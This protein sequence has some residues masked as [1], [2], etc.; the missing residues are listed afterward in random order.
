MDKRGVR[1]SVSSDNFLGYDLNSNGCLNTRTRFGCQSNWPDMLR[2]ARKL[3]VKVIFSN[4][5]AEIVYD[6]LTLNTT[7]KL[8]S[9][10]F[11]SP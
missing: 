1:M 9:R 3:G 4:G 8:Q 5:K 10:L 6:D 7:P 2:Y 11:A